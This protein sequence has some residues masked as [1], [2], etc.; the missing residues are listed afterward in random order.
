MTRV[1]IKSLFTGRLNE[2]DIPA[3]REQLRRWQGGESLLVAMPDLAH[4]HIEFL[5]SGMTRA[6]R[7]KRFGPLAVSQRV[8]KGYTHVL[9]APCRGERCQGVGFR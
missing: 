2:M 6:E 1:Q 3:S 9:I 4:D 7:R 8:C 5:V